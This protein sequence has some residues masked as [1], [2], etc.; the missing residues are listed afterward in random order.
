M[1]QLSAAASAGADA[2]VQTW[3]I[4]G[5]EHIQ[6]YHTMGDEYTRRVVAFFTD[7]LGPAA[8]SVDAAAC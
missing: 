3:L 2:H 5:A 6:S 1:L 4:D 7:A 8:R